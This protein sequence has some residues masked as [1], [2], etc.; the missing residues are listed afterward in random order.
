MLLARQQEEILIMCKLLM[1]PSVMIDAA[2]SREP[3]QATHP[4]MGYDTMRFTLD[5]IQVFE[6]YQG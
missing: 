2:Q 3:H 4:I 1:G 5:L 6:I